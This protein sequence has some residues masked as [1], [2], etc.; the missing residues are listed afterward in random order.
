MAESGQ[1]ALDQLTPAQAREAVRLGFAA[2]Q[3]PPPEVGS[4]RDL[5]YEG[6][7][8]RRALRLYWPPEVPSTR[9]LPACVYFH[10]GG[11]VVGDIPLYDNVCRLLCRASGCAV[12][13]VDYRLAPEA[14]FPAAVEDCWT[15]TRWI[16]EHAEVLGI[17]AARVAVAG[18]SAGG[19]LAAVVALRARDEGKPRLVHQLLI[20]PVTDLRGQTPSYQKNA[21][22]YFLTAALMR[23]F[24]DHYLGGESASATDWRA[25]P[26]LAS[27][28]AGLPPATILV[29][30]FDPLH[31]DGVN[32]AEKLHQ[33]GVA[34]ELI[35]LP[36]QIHGFISMDGAIPAARHTLE[37]V[38]QVLGQALTAA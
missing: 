1:P 38:G 12:I 18:D 23:W 7:T 16:V 36:E 2:L 31:D 6:P 9:R 32:Y 30:G 19:N 11:W 28:H 10:G 22:G 35:R 14:R 8:D 4:I 24:G 5:A 27:S 20:Y 34:A 37:R 21:D 26:L 33:A 25:S 29:C 15:A 13:S 3:G 17:D